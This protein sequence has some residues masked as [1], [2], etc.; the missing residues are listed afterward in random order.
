VKNEIYSEYLFA[1]G[2]LQLKA[3]QMKNFRRL[4]DGKSDPLKGYKLNPI[5]IEDDKVIAVSGKVYH[6]IAVFTGRASD[7]VNGI[8]YNLSMDE[9]LKADEYEVPGYT[10]IQVVLQSGLH[11][12]V[13]V[14]AKYEPAL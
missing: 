4:L 13:Y 2:T 6:K 9:V 8:V 11:S 10:R 7:V 14:D 3:V 1:Y 5:K 12:W